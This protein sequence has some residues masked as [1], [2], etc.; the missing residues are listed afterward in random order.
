MRQINPMR[1]TLTSLF[2]C[3]LAVLIL[4]SGLL[5]VQAAERDEIVFFF[6]D[7]QGSAVAAISEQGE[8]CWSEQYTPYGDK[9]INDDLVSVQGCGVIGEER[10]FTGHTEDVNSDLVYMQ[11]R[12][13]DPSIGRF[14]SVDP[15]AADPNN[16]KTMNRYAYA[17][18]NPYRYTDPDGQLPI[19]V[20][21]VAAIGAALTAY[22]SYQAYKEGGVQAL[23]KTL[24]IEG[25]MVATGGIKLLSKVAKAAD[26]L[27]DSADV[28]SSVP[29]GGTYK[30]RDPETDQVRRTG[31]SNDLDRRA[32]EHGR[33]P[34]TKDLD[35]EVDRRTDSYP[36]QRGR[37]QRIYDLHPE[38]DL[39]KRRGIS[40]R[41][42]KREEY[43]REG[44]KL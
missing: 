25:A 18:N 41:N 4:F 6:N 19:A 44:D 32:R 14:L 10:G 38:A 23:A 21:G 12:Y 5:N 20:L 36:A 17:N 31:R 7:A 13:Y 15:V 42:P 35:F 11:Q 3:C 22:D 16:T 9:V 1:R 24:A 30:L 26:G 27:S 34:N 29:K 8:L 33:D 43:L 39:N 37:E 28:A 40:P 2:Q